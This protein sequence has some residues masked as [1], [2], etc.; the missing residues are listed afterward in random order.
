MGKIIYFAICFMVMFTSTVQAYL[1][2]SSATYILQIVAG[3]FVV[4]GMAIGV[5]WHRIKQLFKGKKG[6]ETTHKALDETVDD[7]NLAD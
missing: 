1:D 3:I 7:E 5:F 2:P 6:A 4:G